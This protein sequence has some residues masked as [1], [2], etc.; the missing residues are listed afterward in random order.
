MLEDDEGGGSAVE[1]DQAGAEDRGRGSEFGPPSQGQSQ[2]G[3][4]ESEQGARVV[5][6]KQR[7]GEK[8]A[9]GEE[10]DPRRRA[11]FGGREEVLRGGATSNEKQSRNRCHSIPTSATH[12]LQLRHSDFYLFFP[13]FFFKK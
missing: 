2:E 12:I 10:E 3:Q 6:D 4:V 9:E 7:A 8:R 13:F 11:S 5:E 1:G